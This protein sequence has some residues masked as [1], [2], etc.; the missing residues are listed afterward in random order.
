M[1]ATLSTT[2]YRHFIG[3]RTDIGKNRARNHDAFWRS[4]TP[5]G[6]LLQVADGVDTLPAPD[7]AARLVI[8]AV[9]EYVQRLPF[10][11]NYLQELRNA[12]VHANQQLFEQQHK[13]PTAKGMACSLVALLIKNNTAWY[14]HTGACRLYLL[15]NEELTQLTTDH[16][17]G[18]QLQKETTA[19]AAQA[20]NHPRKSELYNLLGSKSAEPEVCHYPLQLKPNDQLLLCSSGL[21][22]LIEDSTLRSILAEQELTPQGKATKL[23]NLAN[24]R[25]GLENSTALVVLHRQWQ[26][27]QA[28]AEAAKE[29]ARLADRDAEE[30]KEQHTALYSLGAFLLIAVLIASLFIKNRNDWQEEKQIAIARLDSLSVQQQQLAEALRAQQV[31]ELAR[32]R[33]VAQNYFDPYDTDNYRVYGLYRDAS[34]S[35]TAAAISTQFHVYN[36]SAIKFSEVIGERWFIVP[37]KGIHYFAEGES[38]SELAALYY[39][40]P[41]DSV[42]IKDF[43]QPLQ[44][45]KHIF[46]PFS[47]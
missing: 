27:E 5:N 22:Q 40:R 45:N 14:A 16:S 43:N 21:V 11:D 44:V 9:D 26:G 6:T 4:S 33:A 1:P 39:S 18:A 36:P 34:R 46:I 20:A 13:E 41:A 37:V 17:F 12:F 23:I 38:L 32:A 47:R 28:T 3:V 24:F 29:E 15:R 25:G 31:K 8:K 7:T 2:E 10:R 42:L 19:T 30:E 35:K